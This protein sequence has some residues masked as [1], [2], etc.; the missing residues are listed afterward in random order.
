VPPGPAIIIANE[1]LDCLPSA[2]LSGAT[3]MAGA[4]GRWASNRSGEL[5][6]GLGPPVELPLT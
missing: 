5:V 1:F 2:S 3:A 4:S 6:F